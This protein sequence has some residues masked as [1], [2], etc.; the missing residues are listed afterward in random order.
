MATYRIYRVDPFLGKRK[1]MT[2]AGKIELVRSS[3]TQRALE[4]FLSDESSA[5]PGKYIVMEENA[6]DNAGFFYT[7]TAVPQPRLIVAQ[8]WGEEEED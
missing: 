3:N 5:L 4:K 1:K 2:K 7:V 8:D 6:A